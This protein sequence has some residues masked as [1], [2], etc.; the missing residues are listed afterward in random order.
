MQITAC[1]VFEDEIVKYGASQIACR[2]VPYAA[3]DIRMANAVESDGF[4]LKIL[5][6]SDN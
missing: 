1:E 3:D 5:D 6:L 4:V 2:A